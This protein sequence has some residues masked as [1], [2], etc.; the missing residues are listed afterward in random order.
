G[1]LL[2]SVGLGGIMVI[3]AATY[4]AAIAGLLPVAIPS[5]PRAEAPE[6]AG[7]G[8]V[9]LAAARR[10]VGEAAVGWRFVRER[11]GLLGLLGF[12]ALVNFWAGFVNPLLAPMVLSFGSPVAL[13]TVQA[14]VGAG[15][16]VGG[17][18]IGAWGGPRSRV[19]GLLGAVVV[20]GA[21]IAVTG[22]KTSVPFM[23]AAMFAWSFATPLLMTSSSAIWMSKT[24]QELMGRVTA[25][26]RMALLSLMPLAVLVAGPLADR[27]F[28]PLM[29]PGGALAG[30]VGAAIGVGKG[31]GMALMF[32]GL[33]VLVMLTAVA[34][35][36]VPSIRNVERDV[37]DAP[38]PQPAP[39]SVAEAEP[40]A[41]E[42][43]AD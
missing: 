23:S 11:P 9:W 5:P 31:R 28:E 7:G 35:W 19:A 4:L 42:M 30:S 37:P 12:V 40:A 8:P 6:E 14:S 20:V 15:A 21:C 2:A 32:V 34:A 17:I 43:A 18:V 16:V 38:H 29:A 25:V 33:G 24:P 26:R 27:V 36:L 3:D 1:A 22:L 10:F 13:A 39:G 41:A